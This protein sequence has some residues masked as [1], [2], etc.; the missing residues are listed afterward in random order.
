MRA[1]PFP[2]KHSPVQVFQREKAGEVC[3]IGVCLLGI[4]A[5]SLLYGPYP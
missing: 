1:C 3:E 4:T 5:L 2:Q